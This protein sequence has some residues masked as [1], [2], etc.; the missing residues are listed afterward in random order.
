MGFFLQ[1]THPRAIMPC[2][3]FKKTWCVQDEKMQTFIVLHF[4]Q[5]ILIQ[6]KWI[7][8]IYTFNVLY[9]D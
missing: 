6:A 5:V 1:N 8:S 7:I 4:Y 9:N 2:D 3:L